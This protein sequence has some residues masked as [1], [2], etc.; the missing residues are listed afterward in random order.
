MAGFTQQQVD[1]FRKVFTLFDKDGSGTIDAKELGTVMRSL[2]LDPT[3]EELHDL[4]RE[5]DRDGN[6]SIDFNG[7]SAPAVQP[8]S[9]EEEMRQAFKVF[10][11]DGSGTLSKAE[12]REVMRSLGENITEE[13]LDEMMREVDLD[14]SGTIDFKEFMQLMSRD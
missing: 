9:F 12:V 2:S 10:D 11:K 4:V 8:V 3:E 13:E 1:D 14:K 6:G 7:R 5:A